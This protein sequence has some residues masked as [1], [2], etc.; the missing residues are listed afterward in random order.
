M[1]GSSGRLNTNVSSPFL[2]L[3]GSLSSCSLLTKLSELFYTCKRLPSLQSLR[4]SSCLLVLSSEC[5]IE[6]FI[7]ETTSEPQR[8]FSALEPDLLEA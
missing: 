5:K 8:A 4:E 3:P 1:H 7:L 2:V 6:M